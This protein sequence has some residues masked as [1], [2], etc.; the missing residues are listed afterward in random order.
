MSDIRKYMR[1]RDSKLNEETDEDVL[2]EKLKRH[3]RSKASKWII[4]IAVLII[5]GVG[6][7]IYLDN[8]VYT[9]YEVLET[10]QITDNYNGRFYEFDDYMLRY[11]EDGIAYLN[12]SKTYWNHA[13]EMREPIIDICNS[14]VAVAE[15]KS[16]TI[17]IC[18][19]KGFQGQV[20]T[21]Y[22][23]VG[24]DVSD[25]G[26]VAAIT[27]ENSELSYIEVIDED[28]TR[29]AKGQSVL[30]SQG[31]PVDISISEDGTKLVVSYLCVG[32][33]V[34]QSKVV[35]YNYSE[36]GK[37][38]VDRFV[39]GYNFDK[40]M[41]AR[42]EFVNNDTVVAFGDD[43][44]VLYSMKQKPSVIAE[45]SIDKEIKSIFYDEEYIGLVLANGQA[46]NPY[47]MVVY[48]IEGKKISDVDFNLSYKN[49]KI[50]NKTIILYNDV[51][52]RVYTVKGK[53]KYEGNFDK[54]IVDVIMLDDKYNYLII[55]PANVEKIKLK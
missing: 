1:E 19:N 32:S 6:Y 24:L 17:Y 14:Y 12:G 16:N 37:N 21:E 23:I 25:N 34:I 41:V 33:G 27:G 40:T 29:I 55:D 52:L 49:I 28:G 46:D 13:F 38:E 11:S 15:Q 35:F 30:S 50:A 54:G 47:N 26:I 43:K 48:D 10:A 53:Q 51:T 8:K 36:I 42:V 22:P 18:N 5:A 44:V 4:L 20:E 39:G 7:L 31:C 45:I 2:E 9:S 3:R